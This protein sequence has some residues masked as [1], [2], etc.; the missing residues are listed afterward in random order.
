MIDSHPIV[1][2]GVTGSGKSTLGKALA[3]HLGWTFIEGDD[4]H[5]KSNIEKMSR[6]A[7]LDDADRRPWLE[8]VARALQ[9]KVVAAC[10]ALKRS[11]RE[12]LRAESNCDV[13][14][15]LPQITREEARARL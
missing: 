1:V 15:V 10:S 14:F 4:L 9:P 2:M 3:A 5:P 13:R 7:P 11:Y 12:L 6:G 8:N